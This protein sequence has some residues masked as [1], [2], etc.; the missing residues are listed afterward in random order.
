MEIIL[1]TIYG[2]PIILYLIDYINRIFNLCIQKQNT[3]FFLEC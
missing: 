3:N 2:V 1:L